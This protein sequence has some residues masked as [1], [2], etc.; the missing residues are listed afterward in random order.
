METQATTTLT[1]VAF[2]DG[3]Q[4]QVAAVVVQPVT[5]TVASQ[6]PSASIISESEVQVNLEACP[7]RKGSGP[8][9]S[10][11]GLWGCPGGTICSPKDR[12]WFEPMPA[13][14]FVCD[15]E[16]CVPAPPTFARKDEIQLPYYPLDP[17]RFGLD[18]SVFKAVYTQNRRVSVKY[19]AKLKARQELIEGDDVYGECFTG[20]S[21]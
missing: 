9:K 7:Q 21:K 6:A 3:K 18:Y 11:T 2:V 13:R 15:P 20:C 14:N 5:Y 16:D 19:K 4:R 8:P 10:S 1:T 17:V 12:C